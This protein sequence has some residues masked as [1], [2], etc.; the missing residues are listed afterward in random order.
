M[1]NYWIGF[2]VKLLS[3]I[4]TGYYVSTGNWEGA[5]VFFM[6]YLGELCGS[7]CEAIENKKS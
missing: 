1:K 6:L 3:F 5:A 4:L 7:I 2:W